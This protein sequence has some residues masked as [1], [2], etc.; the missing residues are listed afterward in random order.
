MH[1]YPS[2]P[3]GPTTLRGFRIERDTEEEARPAAA[4]RQH[5]QHRRKVQGRECR[6]RGMRRG[7][8][9]LGFEPQRMHVHSLAPAPEP[10][11]VRREFGTY[12]TVKARFWP[13]P[14]DEILKTF[15]RVPCSLGRW[16]RPEAASRKGTACPGPPNVAYRRQLGPDSGLGFQVKVLTTFE[17]VPSSLKRWARPE[18]ASRKG[19]S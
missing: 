17:V 14:S 2:L 9:G 8:R 13:L 12:K 1:L 19:K 5:A 18:A 15:E 10:A 11:N 4:A 7:L 6:V 3:A 16:V